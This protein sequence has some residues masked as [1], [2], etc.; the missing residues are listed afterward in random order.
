MLALFSF[1]FF[2]FA[3]LCFALLCFALLCFA[4]LCSALFCSVLLYSALLCSALLCFVLLFLCFNFSSFLIVILPF[5]NIPIQRT[6]MFFFLFCFFFYTLGQKYF[7]N[8]LVRTTTAVYTANDE[9]TI[10]RIQLQRQKLFYNRQL[11]KDI[12]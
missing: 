12:N 5:G 2:S 10:V 9:N 1:L 7:T 11:Y 8:S 4:L 6:N 3:L